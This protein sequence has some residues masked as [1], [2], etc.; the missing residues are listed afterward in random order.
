MRRL[1]HGIRSRRLELE[2]LAAGVHR[3]R[4]VTG[5]IGE[6]RQ[7]L[8]QEVLTADLL[9][10]RLDGLEVA[11]QVVMLADTVPWPRIDD[12]VALSFLVRAKSLVLAPS[13]LGFHR[14]PW[15]L[16][17][18]ARVVARCLGAWNGRQHDVMALVGHLRAIELGRLQQRVLV[19]VARGR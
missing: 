15:E 3:G 1:V 18:D 2:I 5:C 8:V 9:L 19:A 7:V 17:R 10:P 11:R 4:G 14:G 16:Q 13:L 12:A 6:H